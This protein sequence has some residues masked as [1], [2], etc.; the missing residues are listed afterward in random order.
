MRLNCDPM[1]A[2]PR[3]GTAVLATALVLL[4][5][6]R[7]AAAGVQGAPDSVPPDLASLSDSIR[8]LV[9]HEDLPGAAVALVLPGGEIWSRGYGV[10]DRSTGRP[11][12]DSTLF[13]IGSTSKMLVGV[14]A[15]QQR[16]R[17]HLELDDPLR[18]LAPALPFDNPWAG[19]RPVRL[20][21]VLEHTAGF[22]G[23]HPPEVYARPERRTLGEALA[24]HP[25][26]RSVRWPPGRF[27]AYSNPGSGVAAFA[28][29]RAAG[30]PFEDY[31]RDEI[32]RPLGMETATY[33]R[34][35]ALSRGLAA[36]YATSGS[37]RA[38]EYWR[39]PAHLRPAG[40]V[41]AS[42]PDVARLVR[43]LIR[44]G[45]LDGRRLLDS[46]SVRRM[47]T[48]T[49]TLSARRKSVPVGYGL[50]SYTDVRNGFVWHGHDGGMDG[51][52][53]EAK[54]LAGHDRG[55][56]ALFNVGN[57]GYG[58]I[59]D[60]IEDYLTRDLA[61]PEPPDAAG[62][63]DLTRHTGYYVNAAP[64]LGLTRF[65]T[66][67]TD[68]RRVTAAEGRLEV[69]VV[70]GGDHEAWVPLGGGRFRGEG[71]PVVTHAVVAADGDRYLQ[72]DG[73][74][75]G[76]YERV[77]ALAVWGRW[78]AT[79][80]VL[81]LVA[82]SLV[83]ALAWGPRALL[84]RMPPE[85]PL[86]VRAWPLL[87]SLGFVA[88]AAGVVSL[89]GA[90]GER[91]T[92]VNAATLGMAL[93]SVVLAGAAAV[94]LVQALRHREAVASRLAWWHSTLVSAAGLL[95]AGWLAWHGLLGIRLWAY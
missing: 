78:S 12:T 43:A 38:V 55:Y 73:G 87:S 62:A 71:E 30:R 27:F 92:T 74:T 54:Y 3:P 9:E 35:T 47:E 40:A 88:F 25:H 94:G 90:S 83:F 24:H 22:D 5:V 76:T 34:E 82:S 11:V 70:P 14:A 31:V 86:Q 1:K 68:V 2:G 50:Q 42:A 56:V 57:G 59:E 61:P 77:P 67:L 65:L 51:Y 89:L 20:A 4:L 37:E 66:T 85:E 69:A 8:A 28:V 81:A 6:P 63:A 18:E 36:G 80:T 93:G 21:H 16:E 17:G 44:D 23:E 53:G 39:M 10:A 52:S 33:D 49:T 15:L 60:L 13:R 72:I 26:S 45:R 29:Q 79:A 91:V 75:A 32:F 41:S 84:G 19:E 64:R 58:K 48:P 95:A 7:P 46:A